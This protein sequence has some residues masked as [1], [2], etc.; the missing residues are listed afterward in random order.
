MAQQN[1]SDVESPEDSE[2]LPPRERWIHS[3]NMDKKIAGKG[4][5]VTDRF[6]VLTENHLYF[7][8]HFE[9]LETSSDHKHA[10]DKDAQQELQAVFK[11]FDKDN[12]GSPFK[13]FFRRGVR[14][15]GRK[16]EK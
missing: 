8:K 9:F 7:S 3:G 12:D 1:G 14:G 10:L 16:Y 4:K 15:K 6:A 2:K 5:T 11:Q 13:T